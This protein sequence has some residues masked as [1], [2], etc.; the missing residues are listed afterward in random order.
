[1][2][3]L[4][5]PLPFLEHGQEFDADARGLRRGK[6][7]APEPRTGDPRHAAMILVD[8]LRERRGLTDGD[9]GA[10]RGLLALAGR[11]LGRAPVA[12]DL[13]RHAGAAAGL[14][15]APVGGVLSAR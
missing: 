8:N 1:M 10:S 4:A 11:F 13:L 2:A 15:Q 6:R 12:R 14:R 5:Y 9:G 7:V 3:L